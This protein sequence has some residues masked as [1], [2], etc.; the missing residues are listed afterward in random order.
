MRKRKDSRLSSRTLVRAA[1]A[2]QFAATILDGEPQG[3][4]S[5]G[6]VA[7]LDQHRAEARE[8]L[9]RYGL[10]LDSAAEVAAAL[11]P[12]RAVIDLID[13]D[14]RDSKVPFYAVLLTLASAL[15]DAVGGVRR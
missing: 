14:N 6:G 11:V 7:A 3:P 2:T 15:D 9:D 13:P 1:V 10:D 12:C 8:L 4:Q 5:P